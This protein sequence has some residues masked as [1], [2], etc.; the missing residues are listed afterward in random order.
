MKKI[1]VVIPCYNAAEY[2][3]K[4]LDSLAVQTFK[5]FD[6]I[7]VDDC[8]VDE[9]VDTINR[10]INLYEFDIVL[11][12]N[13]LNSG[14]SFSRKKG[15]KASKTKYVS[16]CDCDDWYDPEY[17]ERMIVAIEAEKADVVFCG[18]KVISRD[19]NV[20][21]RSFVDRSCVFDP[22]NTLLLG[23]DSMCM[24]VAKR[25]L[26]DNLPWPNVRNG[27]D[28]AIVPLL[29]CETKK[30]VVIQDCLYNY[31]NRPSSASN[32]LSMDVVDSLIN[33]YCFIQS[34]I[35]QEFEYECEYIGINNLIYAGLITLFSV[36]GSNEK[37][38]EILDMFELTYPN[39]GKNN[40]IK[41]LPK[42]KKIIIFLASKRWFKLLRLVAIIRKWRK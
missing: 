40:H 30:N 15:V 35:P 8:S 16:F 27:E 29:I 41:R 7:I 42:Y 34:N 36:T 22:K 31:Y 18:Y 33:S 5:D 2:I 23:L 24:L 20:E 19:G 32:R 12:K 39:W 37:A 9:T 26:F 4:C 21:M 11:L 28:M 14:P 6:V 10:L 38:I 13:E 25:E 1:S 3:K 17:L